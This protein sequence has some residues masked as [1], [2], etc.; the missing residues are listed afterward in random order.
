MKKL[1]KKNKSFNLKKFVLEEIKNIQSGK[2]K[3]N[4]KKTNKEILDN[5]INLIEAI[6][7]KEKLLI[8]EMKALAKK[9]NN[10][11]NTIAQFVDKG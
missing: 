7:N 10:I 8:K 4:K 1:K 6:E 2:K 9:K 11:K 3:I 5:K